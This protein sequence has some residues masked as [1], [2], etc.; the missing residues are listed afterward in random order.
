MTKSSMF[1]AAGLITLLIAAPAA[2]G[3]TRDGE[4][5]RDDS[6]GWQTSRHADAIRDSYR[7]EHGHDRIEDR[8]GSRQDERRAYA[9]G[10]RDASRRNGYQGFVSCKYPVY[11]RVTYGS[12]VLYHAGAQRT[13]STRKGPYWVGANGRIACRRD[14]GSTGVIV[15][16]LAGGTLGNILAQSGDKKVGS[17]IGGTLGALLGKELD[18]GNGTC[19]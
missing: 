14:D 18:R 4:R 13:L 5:T 17:I 7:R 8:R 3:S 1:A 9:A 19:R 11:G 16:A 15:G 12:P 10:Y 2:A 6:P